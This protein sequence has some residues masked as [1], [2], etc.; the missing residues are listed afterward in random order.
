MTQPSMFG[1]RLETETPVEKG[2]D[3]WVKVDGGLLGG[4][5][6]VEL[7]GTVAWK[8]SSSE[9]E[10]TV[11]GIQLT[12]NKVDF[13]QWAA[14]IRGRIQELDPTRKGAEMDVSD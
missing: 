6:E 8:E 9:T 11:C 5:G 7:L 1:L 2:E 14:L 13:K 3:L 4:T 10:R 12:P